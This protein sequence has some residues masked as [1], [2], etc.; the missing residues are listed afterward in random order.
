MAFGELYSA[1]PCWTL[2]VLFLAQEQKK[3]APASKE[4]FSFLIQLLSES[5]G[6]AQESNY[7]FSETC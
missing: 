7:L 2:L 6:L 4:E 1:A 3:G 5:T